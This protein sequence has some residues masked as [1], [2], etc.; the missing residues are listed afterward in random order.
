MDRQS[1][2]EFIL[3]HYEN[4]RNHGKLENADVV[5]DG[6]LVF[7]HELAHLVLFHAAEPI[8]EAFD[9]LYGVAL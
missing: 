4:P 3:D 5:S 6:G 7:A 2:I 8:V 9:E 1:Q